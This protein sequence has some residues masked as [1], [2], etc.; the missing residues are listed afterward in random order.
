MILAWRRISAIIFDCYSQL[1][2]GPR[3]SFIYSNGG[4]NW[5]ANALTNI[6]RQGLRRLSHGWLFTP[7]GVTANDIRWRTPAHFYNDLVYGLPA[8]EFNGGMMD[9]VNAMAAAGLFV[10]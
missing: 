7:P 9:N 8:T 1:Q 3:S 6:Y 2:A 5:L 10:T 4:T